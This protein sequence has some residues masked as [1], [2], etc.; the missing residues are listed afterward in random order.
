M[1]QRFA[2]HEKALLQAD[3]R[4]NAIKTIKKLASF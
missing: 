2:D 4:F 3:S 1:A